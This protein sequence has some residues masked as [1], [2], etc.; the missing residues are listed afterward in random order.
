VG[1]HNHTNTLNAVH[2]DLVMGSENWQYF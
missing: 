1:H 2:I